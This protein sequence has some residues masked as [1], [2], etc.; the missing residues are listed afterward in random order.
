M[1]EKKEPREGNKEGTVLEELKKAKV[2][3]RCTRRNKQTEA[4]QNENPRG[5]GE[6]VRKEV[7]KGEGLFK[8]KKKKNEE[9][10]E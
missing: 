2:V 10:G 7:R 3:L 6:K 4:D 8:K 5:N 9:E 1:K